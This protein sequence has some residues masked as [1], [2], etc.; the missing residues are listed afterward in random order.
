[1]ATTDAPR[2]TSNHKTRA[3]FLREG[4][5]VASAMRALLPLRRRLFPMRDHR[6]KFVILK[7][8][9]ELAVVAFPAIASAEWAK[10][11]RHLTAR[12][13]LLHMLAARPMAAFAAYIDEL[14]RAKFPPVARRCAEAH[15]V[16]RDAIRIRVRLPRDERMKSP[17]VPAAFPD[18]H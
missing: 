14:R 8:P 7:R 2:N 18:F 4:K 9:A 11:R 12:A 10:L 16:A 5:V 15:R 1:M 6:P 3:G 17:P 13:P